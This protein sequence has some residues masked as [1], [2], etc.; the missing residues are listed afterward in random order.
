MSKTLLLMGIVTMIIGIGFGVAE[1]INPDVNDTFFS[2]VIIWTV[3]A[4]ATGLGLK[5]YEKEGIYQ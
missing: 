3:G 4:I 1:L 5:M 2:S